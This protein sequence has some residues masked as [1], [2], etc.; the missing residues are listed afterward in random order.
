MSRVETD[1]NLNTVDLIAEARRPI[2]VERHRRMIEEMESG[3]S[4]VFITGASDNPRLQTMLG[5]LDAPIARARVAATITALSE[6]FHYRAHGV[7][8]ALIE[9]MCLMRERQ[10]VEV[11]ALQLHTMG[12]YRELRQLLLAVQ[13][14]APVISDLRELPC[15]AVGR[16]TARERP[17]FGSPRLGDAAVYTP[18][19]GERCLR[20]IK[21][22]HRAEGAD[23][24][25]DDATG[26]PPL[27]RELEEPLAALPEAERVAARQALIRDRIRSLFFRDVFLVHFDVDTFDPVENAV[28]PTIL[29]WLETIEATPHLFPFMQGQTSGQKSFRLSQ[30]LQKLIQLHEM[31]ARAALA[32]QHPTYREAFL[33]MPTRDRLKVLAKDRYPPLVLSPELTLATLLCPFTGLAAWVQECVAAKDFVLP[34]DPRRS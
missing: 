10:Q 25:W 34:P 15:T 2:L 28:H 3:I 22:L 20:V 5:E 13:G 33:N 16:L 23:H 32:G 14:E 26:P 12:V 21:R 24:Q 27:A 31:Y 19:F 18:A 6:D 1:D 30:L 8:L 9:E 7:R 29:H 17:G 11:A 4:D